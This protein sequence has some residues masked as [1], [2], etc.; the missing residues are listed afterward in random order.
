MSESKSSTSAVAPGYRN[1]KILSYLPEKTTDCLNGYKKGKQISSGAYG[2]VSLACKDS[3]AGSECDDYVIKIS[4]GK[5]KIDLVASKLGA[6][7]IQSLQE[8]KWTDVKG[9]E[10]YLVP[11]YIW[12]WLCDEKFYLV[13]EKFSGDMEKKGLEQYETYVDSHPESEFSSYLDTYLYTETQMQN[14]FNIAKRLD[15]LGIIQ[16]DLK[17]GQI[18]YRDSSDAM[19]I[20]DFDLLNSY[21]WS[22]TGLRGPGCPSPFVYD[23]SGNVLPILKDRFNQWQ[24]ANWMQTVTPTYVISDDER[25]VS[26][27]TGI[28]GIPK[29]WE[30]EL[31]KTCPRAVIRRNPEEKM[32]GPFAE[33]LIPS[34]RGR[35]IPPKIP[36]TYPPGES[37]TIYTRNMLGALQSKLDRGSITEDEFNDALMKYVLQ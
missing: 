21:S 1:L 24:L 30:D 2:I 27:F 15:E 17:P 7:L 25:T 4:D 20:T 34:L 33:Y 37:E 29:T 6:S 36:K 26:K 16:G 13:L 32:V 23:T 31:L 19:V 22:S 10:Q 18:L 35:V 14:M 28:T 3:K 11:R 5:N 9:K 8:E 12:S